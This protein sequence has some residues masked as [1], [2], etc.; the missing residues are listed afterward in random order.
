[1]AF[2]SWQRCGDG[3]AFKSQNGSVNFRLIIQARYDVSGT[4]YTVQT[5]GIILTTQ[6]SASYY[7]S[8]ANVTATINGVSVYNGTSSRPSSSSGWSTDYAM[9]IAGTNYIKGFVLSDATWQTTVASTG[10][11][12]TITVACSNETT[13]TNSWAPAKTKYTASGTLTLPAV[14]IKAS[15]TSGATSYNF[16][17]NATFT[18]KPGDTTNN[19]TYTVRYSWSNIT[20]TIQNKLSTTNVT[21]AIPT[22]LMNNIPNASSMSGV[23]VYVDTYVGNTLVGTSQC[24]ITLNVPNDIV[25]TIDN[26]EVTEANEILKSLNLGTFVQNV[27]KLNVKTTASG[28]YNSTIKQYNVLLDEV[29]YTGSDIISNILIA[30]RGV[31]G[32]TQIISTVTDSRGRS[33]NSGI[34]LYPYAQYNYPVISKFETRRADDSGNYDDNGEYVRFFFKGTIHQIKLD[35]VEKNTTR[36]VRISYRRRD[37]LSILG[38]ILDETVDT[39]DEDGNYVF[40]YEDVFHTGTKFSSDEEYEFIYEVIDIIGTTKTIE[41]LYS[42]FNLIDFNRD[43]RSMSFGKVCDLPDGADTVEMGLNFDIQKELTIKGVKWVD[44]IYPIGSIYMSWNNTNPQNL[45]GGEWTQMSNAFLYAGTTAGNGNGTGTSTNNT[46]LTANQSG[47]PAHPHNA[48]YSGANFYI[49]HGQS[50][51]T[52]IVAAGTNTT[53][54]TGAYSGTWANGISTQSYSHK[55]DRVQ[56]N[57]TVTVQNSTATNAK[58]GHNHA[59]PYISVYMWRRTG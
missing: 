3:V 12:K 8:K 14:Y 56:I 42:G 23:I 48:S 52:D 41:V 17:S 26:V 29:I 45:F 37:T 16:G 7:N 2:T 27:S 9:T 25:P 46:T 50:S 33:T 38:T 32:R 21:W 22:T 19:Y 51:G 4:T 40:D 24:S 18:I 44:L 28:V 34:L 54:T 15:I 30:D 5:R 13:Y 6:T 36:K 55:P 11:A 58:E 57:G 39:T 20:G 47:I 31:E 53:I 43:G 59:I 49:R 10:P 35:G 1:M